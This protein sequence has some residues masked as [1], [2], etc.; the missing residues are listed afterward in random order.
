M[1]WKILGTALILFVVL[2]V[3]HSAP[4]EKEQGPRLIFEN[5]ATVKV[6]GILSTP[7]ERTH[8]LMYQR[9]LDKDA[10]L[11]FVFQEEGYPSFWMKNTYIPLDI[12][13]FDA[14]Y[15][16]VHI[17]P[18]VHPTLDENPPKYSPPVPAQYVLEVNAGYTQTHGIETGDRAV[19]RE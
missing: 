14:D 9:K 10:G 8:G 12:I 7:E 5:G 16:V 3:Y 15:R 4:G 18:R 1:K 6:V 19:F 13:W 11:L 2:Q 17:E